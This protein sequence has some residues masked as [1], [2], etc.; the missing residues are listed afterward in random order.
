MNRELIEL[1]DD[2]RMIGHLHIHSTHDSVP[3]FDFNRNGWDVHFH[4]NLGEGFEIKIS[5]KEDLESILRDVHH[6]AMTWLS[7]YFPD[8]FKELLERH[9]TSESDRP[10]SPVPANVRCR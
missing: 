8:Y 4:I 6:E 1:L 5:K 3:Y 7:F 2:F 10:T 9:N